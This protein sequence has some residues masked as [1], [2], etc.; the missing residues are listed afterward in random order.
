[1]QIEIYDMNVTDSEISIQL[2]AVCHILNLLNLF[3]L[4][5]TSL[6]T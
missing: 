2:M 4:F 1:M 5:R 6:K 3:I